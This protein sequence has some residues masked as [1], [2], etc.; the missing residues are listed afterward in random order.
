L[1]FDDL[2]KYEGFA[3][4]GESIVSTA[5]S[6]FSRFMQSIDAVAWVQEGHKR[7]A[8]KSDGK[9]PYCQ[10]S[11]KGIEIDIEAEIEKS[12]S[13]KYAEDCARLT[14]YQQ[15][16]ASYTESFIGTVQQHIDFLKSIPAGF[17]DVG[18]YELNLAKLKETVTRN[19]QTIAAKAAKPS[20]EVAIEPI[21]TYIEAINALIADTN[22]LFADNNAIFAHKTDEKTA[23]LNEVW[24][25]LAFDLQETLR[26]YHAANKAFEA[27]LKALET[28]R[29]RERENRRHRRPCFEYGQ[30]CAVN[31]QFAGA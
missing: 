9:C 13:G 12:F 25:M 27:D 18:A 26:K 28:R 7:Y 4:L 22:K 29:P 2:Q 3:L 14:S 24:E 17:G 8:P 20:E 15:K 21:G 16:Y 23:V 31:C 10:Q 11:I 6:A 19:N 5:D 1:N 30:Q